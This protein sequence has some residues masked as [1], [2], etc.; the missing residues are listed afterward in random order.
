MTEKRKKTTARLHLLTARQ[1]LNAGDGDHSDGGGLLLRVRGESASWV[2]RYTSPSGRR[3]EMGLG[4]AFRGSAAQAGETL[5]AARDSAHV[6]REQL[7]VDIDPIDARDTRRESERQAEEARKADRARERWTLARCGR[8]YHERVIEPTKTTRHA[9]QWIASLENHV[10]AAVWHRRIDEITPPELLAAL[11]AV[12][13]HERARRHDGDTVPETLRRIRQRLEVIFADATFYGRCATNPAAAIKHKMREAMPRAKAGAFAALPYGEAPGFMQRLRAMPG[14]AARCLEFAVLT[15][16]RTQEAI[17]AAWSEI[18][19][20]AATW[21]VPAERMKS[22]GKEKAEEHL[23]HLSPRAVEVLRAQA[24]QDS[25][26]V[27]PS[28]V[29][30]D[31]DDG[32]R[33]G[34]SNMALL[35]TLDRLGMRDRTTVHGLCRSTFSTWANDTGAARPD[36]IEACLA[37]S[38]RDKVRAAY[39]RAQFNAERRAL[40]AAWADYLASPAAQVLPFEERAA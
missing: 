14:T 27:F 36:V 34:L 24:G 11:L 8:D 31:R 3:R 22:S 28:P 18:N 32:D 9:A 7:R 4:V 1:V 13:P 5:T 33:Q 37:H 29:S 19:L 30:M 12:K 20:E 10:P 15:A 26:L 6:A 38:E 40:L 25:R 17:G 35:A 16:A 21:L 39:N 2:F 23:V